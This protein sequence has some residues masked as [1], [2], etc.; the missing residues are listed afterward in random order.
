[1]WSRLHFAR[2]L[3]TRLSRGDAIG[4]WSGTRKHFLI[5]STGPC[6][7][8]TP[9]LRASLAEPAEWKHVFVPPV[10]SQATETLLDQERTIRIGPMPLRPA[11]GAQR[12]DSDERGR[13]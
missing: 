12:L 3:G 1:M 6:R 5:G 11:A 10:V 2:P 9:A 13:R 8:R 7:Q 4:E